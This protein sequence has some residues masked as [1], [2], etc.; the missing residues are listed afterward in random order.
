MTIRVKT[1][2]S[3]WEIV[4]FL[5]TV[6]VFIRSGSPFSLAYQS[7]T[8]LLHI[9]MS[10]VIIVCSLICVPTERVAPSLFFLGVLF[11]MS[12][13]YSMFS[14]NETAFYKNYVIQVLMC[15]D[16][17]LIIRLIGVEKTIRYWI[18]SMRTIVFAALFLYFL[19]ALGTNFFPAIQT[20]TSTYHTVF[21]A[22]QLTTARRICGSFWEPSMFVVFLSFTILF[23]L[24]SE[25]N[26]T[27]KN[28]FWITAEI[29]ALFLTFSA[30]A[31][32]ALLFIGFIYYYKKSKQ[33]GYFVIVVF[34]VC[35]LSMVFFE[36][37]VMELYQLFPSV[38]Y[39]FVEKDISFLTRVNNPIGDMLTC[40]NNP[41]GV[42]VQNVENTVR[43]YAT[44][45][46]GET[47]AVISRTATW[48]YYFAAFGWVAGF[49]VN[50][51]WIIGIIASHWLKGIQ[52]LA[53]AALFF[54]MLTSVTLVNN[55]LYWILLV[56]I[57]MS[58][59]RTKIETR[60][61]IDYMENEYYEE[62]NNSFY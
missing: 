38:F 26:N 25:K 11:C 36:D 49:A 35:I 28:R 4:V 1:K 58:S 3:L 41:F 48:S 9:L 37:I 32:V 45:F 57:N 52:K 22:S 54:Y 50:L 17:I 2:V 60:T 14:A 44:L 40:I 6:C 55:Q 42:G 46:T 59:Q 8:L 15:V 56:L 53:F 23:E 12:V 27:Q 10:F 34:V 30:S 18:I 33:R 51:I 47:R 5:V 31:F 43:Y 7:T 61:P 29:L 13:F 19:I 62:T 16:A 21:F 39:K 24:L 20:P